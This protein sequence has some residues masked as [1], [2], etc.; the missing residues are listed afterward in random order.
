MTKRSI[1][2][3]FLK[4]GLLLTALLALGVALSAF[5]KT[6][7][8]VLYGT[9]KDLMP[10]VLS[11]AATWLGFCIQR[12]TAFHQQLRVLWSSLVNAV[13]LAVAYTH[14]KTPTEQEY[15][16]VLVKLSV[17]IDEFRGVFCN[18]GE[19]ETKRGYYPFEPVKDMHRLIAEL[20][21]GKDFKADGA[22]ACRA[23][24]L[25]LWEDVRK[26]LLKEFDRE[27]PTFPHSH[28][29]D[30]AKAQVYEQHQITK[31]AQ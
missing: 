1:R 9:F 3:A 13:Q 11:I 27:E 26:E 24:V 31:G 12:R 21:Y 10:L 5:D 2:A 15:G 4:T 20:G 29:A 17:A 18:L 16:A 19:T 23:H 22:A 30:L 7:G 8:R 14:D 6:P 25:R 28:W